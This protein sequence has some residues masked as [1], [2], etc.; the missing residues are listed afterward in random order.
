VCKCALGGMTEAGARAL[1]EDTARM[2]LYDMYQA[3][4][5]FE[6]PVP[7]GLCDKPAVATCTTC[8][9]HLCE[10]CSKVHG[11]Q[12]LTRG[13]AIVASRVVHDSPG[14]FKRDAVC[15][16]HGVPYDV[17]CR[18]CDGPFCT[19]CALVGHPK[20]H[21]FDDIGTVADALRESI[22][23]AADAVAFSPEHEA[24]F[25]A[26]SKEKV[27]EAKAHGAEV[28]AAIA[29]HYASLHDLLNQCQGRAERA[30]RAA[31][32]AQDAELGSQF[33]NM[34][35]HCYAVQRSLDYAR[36]TIERGTNVDLS[37][38]HKVL[39][40]RLATAAPEHRAMALQPQCAP[41]VSITC[42]DVTKLTASIEASCV[43]AQSKAVADCTRCSTRVVCACPPLPARPLC[44]SVFRVY[45]FQRCWNAAVWCGW[46][47]CVG[48]VFAAPSHGTSQ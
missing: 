16:V 6:H 45:D 28:L 14:A 35:L 44:A 37:L 18:E 1:V 33:K 36:D 3:R 11:A 34:E 39:L 22:G 8:P 38:R 32:A 17:H 2:R 41:P 13:H 31:V 27:R 25:K 30:V 19:K 5:A 48:L 29:A 15:R 12:K 10:D 9:Q 43:I 21:T 40:T 24:A 47:R 26:A 46:W 7:C 20:W 4:A 42:S 23:A